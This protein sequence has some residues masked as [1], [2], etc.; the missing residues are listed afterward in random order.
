MNYHS[1]F[2]FKKVAELQ[3]LTK[4]AEELYVAQPSLS[5]SI[6]SLEDELGVKLFDRVGKNIVLN[7]FGRIVLRHADAIFKEEEAIYSEIADYK[8]EGVKVVRLSMRAGT[9]HLGDL[10]SGFV[11]IHPDIKVSTLQGYV[12]KEQYDKLDFTIFARNRKKEDPGEHLLYTERILVALPIDHP[13]ASHQSIDIHELEGQRFLSLP[14]GNAMRDLLDE[15]CHNAGFEPNIFIECDPAET[16]RKTLRLGGVISLVPEISWDRIS[17]DTTVLRP[18]SKPEGKRYMYLAE[19]NKA[20]LSDSARIFRK[21]M[22][23]FFKNL[24]STYSKKLAGSPYGKTVG[25]KTSF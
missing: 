14:K 9:Q 4:A 12:T 1:L 24:E 25:N 3:H 11:K 13:L 2:Y 19:R 8:K 20:Y 15:Y 18:L 5:R 22:L 10:L 21:Y 17:T 23:E 6:S 16:V 7:D